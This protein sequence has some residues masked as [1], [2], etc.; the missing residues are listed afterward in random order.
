MQ[1]GQHA[2]GAQE[3]GVIVRASVYTP[4]H[5]RDAKRARLT[6]ALD[7][8]PVGGDCPTVTLSGDVHCPGLGSSR[9]LLVPHLAPVEVGARVSP[10]LSPQDE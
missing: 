10:G 3:V 9:G 4:G 8:S 2:L 7:L 1:R 6:P 5:S